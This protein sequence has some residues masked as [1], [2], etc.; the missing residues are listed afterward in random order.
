M[1]R[2]ASNGGIRRFSERRATGAFRGS[3]H[4]ADT[5]RACVWRGSGLP[6]MTPT[7]SDLAPAALLRR[8]LDVGGGE[9]GGFGDGLAG[10]TEALKVE[11]DR[12]VYLALDLLAR[13][14]GVHAAGEV[15]RLRRAVGA[16]G[17]FEHEQVL[18]LGHQR[19]SSPRLSLL[20]LRELP[21]GG[22]G[23]P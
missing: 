15:R 17:D 3:G 19:F 12:V 2:V 9:L 21:P 10:V 1:A 20:R 6:R 5:A 22:R 4:V 8:D 7:A 23:A 18:P 14:A 16:L 13:H 11:G